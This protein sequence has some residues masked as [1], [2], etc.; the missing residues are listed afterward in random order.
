MGRDIAGIAKNVKA[1]MTRI[2]SKSTKKT[3]KG[4]QKPAKK[5]TKKKTTKKKN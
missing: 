3:D 5:T 2:K 1:L 4:K